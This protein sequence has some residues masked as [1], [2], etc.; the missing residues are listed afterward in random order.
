[1]SKEYSN[2]VPFNFHIDPDNLQYIKELCKKN[3]WKIGEYIN[4]LIQRGLD[5]ENEKI[6]DNS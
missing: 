2:K 4:E 1:M 5:K 3:R 6:I